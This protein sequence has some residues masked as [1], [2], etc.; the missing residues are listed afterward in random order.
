MHAAN[1][2]IEPKRTLNCNAPIVVTKSAGHLFVRHEEDDLA[3][4]NVWPPPRLPSFCESEN[5]SS[6]KLLLAHAGRGVGKH[7][8]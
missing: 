8:S 4:S 3:D 7:G 5:W 6:L 2:E 1:F